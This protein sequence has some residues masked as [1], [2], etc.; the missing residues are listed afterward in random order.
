MHI[1]TIARVLVLL[2]SLCFAAPQVA[3]QTLGV[4]SGNVLTAGDSVTVTYSN[5]GMPGQTVD[6]E[7]SGGFPTVVRTL[8]IKLDA[9][10]KGSGDWT[11]EGWSNASF[12]APGASQVTMPISS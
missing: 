10:G 5:P 2:F 11:V 6:I 4:G 12:N 3:A 1:L 7:I 8:R 9:D